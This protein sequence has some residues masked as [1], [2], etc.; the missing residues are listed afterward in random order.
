MKGNTMA[1]SFKNFPDQRRRNALRLG[2]A[3]VL[4]L[5]APAAAMAAALAP[6]TTPK[7]VATGLDPLHHVILQNEYMRVMRVM[8]RPGQST[9]FHDQRL[10]YVN[11]ILKGS[12]SRIDLLDGSKPSAVYMGGNTIRFGDHRVH[13]IVDEVTNTGSTIIE[14][15]AF[16]IIRT[17]PGNFGPADRSGAKQFKLVLDKPMVRGWRLTLEP[18]EF[19]DRYVQSGPGLRVI[20]RGQRVIDSPPDGVG[21]ETKVDAG[22]AMFTTAANRIV[23]NGS[24]GP[25][26]LIEYE[27]L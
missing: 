10:D 13:P 19:T 16:E 25:L 3:S 23:T 5:L 18:G 17:S 15:I 9:E 26:E 22:D 7:V 8:I 21:H 12:M 20:I 1:V 6:I 11:T 27:L 24:D 14:Q 2:G 4:S